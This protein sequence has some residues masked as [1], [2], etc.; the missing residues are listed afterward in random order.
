MIVKIHKG[1]DGSKVIAVCDRN[2][3]GK[4]Y[5]DGGMRLNL[6]CEFYRGGEMKE[7]RLMSEIRKGPCHLNA[8]GEESVGFCIKKGLVDKEN[9][10]RIKDIPHAQA[11][12]APEQ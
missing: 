1:A 8:A 2:L 3:L 6:D 4:V 7:D 9:I 12:I 11:A 10:I 5:E